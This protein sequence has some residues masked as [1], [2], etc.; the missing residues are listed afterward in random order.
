MITADKVISGKDLRKLL[1]TLKN[2]KEVAPGALKANSGSRTKLIK[3]IRD[4]YFFSLIANTGLRISEALTLHQN[5][6]FEDYLIIRS[7]N[8]KNKKPGTVYFGNKTKNL[9]NELI[10][11]KKEMNIPQANLLGFSHKKSSRSYM[12]T[13]FKMWLALSNISSHY[14]V[15]SLRHTYATVCLDQELSITF[16]RDNLRHSNLSVTS[17]YLHLTKENREKVKEIF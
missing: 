2:E 13:R 12:H 17:Q 3:A 11:L 6:V 15:H 7:K 4:Y 9:I 1:K 5:D 10:Q 14:S 16:V 8:S